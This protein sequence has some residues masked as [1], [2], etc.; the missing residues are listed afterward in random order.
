MGDGFFVDQS[1]Y[2]RSGATWCSIVISIALI[3][4]I[5]FSACFMAALTL[6]CHTLYLLLL[7][8][9]EAN[10][11]LEGMPK[12]K[13]RPPHWPPALEVSAA[14]DEHERVPEAFICL[15]SQHIMRLPV[16]TRAGTTYD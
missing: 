8:Q 6:L 16:M 12:G 15:I 5:S 14:A 4:Y 11:L 10:P 3:H 13:S 2:Y 9:F 7:G 1:S